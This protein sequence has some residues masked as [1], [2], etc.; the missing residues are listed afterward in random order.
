MNQIGKIGED[1]AC[2]LLTGK[3]YA[4]IK[5]NAIVGG[6]EVDILAQHDS[7]LV[8]VEVKTRKADHWDPHFGLDREKM[9]RLCR[10]G[11]SYVKSQNLPLEVQIDAV[12]IVNNPDGSSSI[13][14]LE[15]IALPPRRRYR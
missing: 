11:A 4:I 12:L 2:G 8:I 3:G 15:D 14:H 10:A 5:R 6:V 7:R 13:D 1:L 9:R